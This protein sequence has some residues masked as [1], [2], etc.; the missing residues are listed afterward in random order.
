MNTR[1]TD[2]DLCRCF[3]CEIAR[4]PKNVNF[5][6]DGKVF[7]SRNNTFAVASKLFDTPIK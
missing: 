1:S 7:E 3:I 2:I 6:K 4:F 5:S